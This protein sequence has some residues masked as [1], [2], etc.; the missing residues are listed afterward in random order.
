[1]RLVQYVYN[2]PWE[3]KFLKGYEKGLL[4]EAA[5]DLLPRELLYRRKSPYPKTWNPEY[6][7]LVRERFRSIASDA[8]SPLRA[9]LDFDA[10][11]RAT[12]SASPAATPWFGQLMTAPQMLAYL[13]QIDRW[14]RAY[15]V[16]VE[17]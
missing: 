7:R 8:A 3:M 6:M 15:G 17:L 11:E 10:V 13:I 2:V 4:R 9:F 16:R 5:R 14:M 12:A 1:M